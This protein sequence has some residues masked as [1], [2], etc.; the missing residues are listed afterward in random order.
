MFNAAS[1]RVLSF[2]L[3][4]LAVV[5]AWKGM[6]SPFSAISDLRIH[7]ILPGSVLLVITLEYKRRSL[8]ALLT[9]VGNTVTEGAGVS[10]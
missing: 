5:L 1:V 3:L 8:H 10:R 6:S 2:I 9:K 7:R 4:R